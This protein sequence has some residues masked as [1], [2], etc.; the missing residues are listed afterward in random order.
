MTAAKFK[1]GSLVRVRP[2][3]PERKYVLG[4]Y[5][6]TTSERHAMQQD[7]YFRG[8]DDAGEPRTVPDSGLLRL[9]PG[10]LVTV[11]RARVRPPAAWNCSKGGYVLVC[12]PAVGREVYIR[13]SYLEPLESNP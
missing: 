3:H 9:E 8:M 5:A 11:I 10:S 2:L 13:E 7:P 1:R 4:L 12:S 6:L